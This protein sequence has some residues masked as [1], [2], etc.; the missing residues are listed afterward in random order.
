MSF[1]CPCARPTLYLW[2]PGLCCQVGSCPLKMERQ[3]QPKK[4]FFKSAHFNWR[5]FVKPSNCYMRFSQIWLRKFYKVLIVYIV[6]TK[7]RPRQ[8]TRLPSHCEMQSDLI[9]FTLNLFLWG[10]KFITTLF[11]NITT[12][13]STIFEVLCFNSNGCHLGII[14]FKVNMIQKWPQQT[15]NTLQWSTLCKWWCQHLN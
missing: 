4:N 1:L 10:Q 9:S 5:S 13:I 14:G 11:T 3:I 7:H 2:L 15:N 12:I 6:P 8:C